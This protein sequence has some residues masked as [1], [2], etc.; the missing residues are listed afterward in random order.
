MGRA[1]AW[2]GTRGP[3]LL[4]GDEVGDLGALVGRE[5]DIG[6][7]GRDVGGVVLLEVDAVEAAELLE[8]RVVR[9]GVRPRAPRVQ[10]RR[11]DARE[12]RRH[13]EAEDGRRREVRVLDGPVE[14]RVD[15]RARDVDGHAL[16]DAVAAAGPARV[17]EVG[18]R[19][20]APELVAEQVRVDRRVEREEG[21]AEARGERRRRL[22][23]AALRAGDLGRVAG[24]E[25]VHG[26]ALAQ[27]RHGRQDAEGVAGEEDHGLRVARG[28]RPVERPDVVDRVRH[29]AVGRLGQ[30]RVVRRAAFGVERDVLEHGVRADRFEDVGLRRLLQV[31]GLGVAAA[32]EVED[33]RVVPAVL[34]V[35]D[36]RALRVRGERRLARAAEAEEERDVAGLADVRRAVHREDAP[37]REQVV[38]EREDAL[39]VLAAVVGA[40]DDRELP[41][42]VEGDGDVA[43]Q[44]VRLPALVPQRARVDD[45]EVHA[46]VRRQEARERLGPDEHVRHEVLLPRELVHE[47]DVDA[48]ARARAAVQVRDVDF[49]EA[50]EVVDGP[51]EELV[52]DLGPHGLVHGAPPEVLL[53]LGAG[54]PHGPLVAR[55]PARELARVHGE[56]VPVGRAREDAL[57]VGELVGPEL[58]EG[59]V[60]EDRRRPRDAERVEARGLAGLV[61]G[62][63]LR[64]VV[65]RA[66]DRG[67]DA[68]RPQAIPGGVVLVVAAL[69]DERVVAGAQ[70]AGLLGRGP[71]LVGHGRVRSGQRQPAQAQERARG[72]ARGEHDG[73]WTC[74]W[75]GAMSV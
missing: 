22:G 53:R 57:A 27:A 7:V 65:A 36:E 4:A 1:P 15:A 17:D 44:A 41:L 18:R 56:R 31:R 34:V 29:A 3:L 51:R 54:A 52:E 37:E 33:A 25:V 23:D 69:L 48:R 14:D 9:R 43:V 19:A 5:G 11:V 38:H 58:L 61:A 26:L 40:V 62:E 28:L 74:K 10:E 73:V 64:D 67:R 47:A 66:R 21:R 12:R 75:C 2:G 6:P 55:R 59:Q 32:L 45:R 71:G 20:V 70:L 8:R 30:I 60:A 46:L 68:L 35:A 63:R 72:E 49:V 16:A 39:L 50:V 42:E 24:E 13:V